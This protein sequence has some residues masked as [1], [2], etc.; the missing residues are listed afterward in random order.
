[1]HPWE[2][3][4]VGSLEEERALGYPSTHLDATVRG[5]NELN[6]V[7]RVVFNHNPK[8]AGTAIIAALHQ[9]KLG[10]SVPDGSLVIEK[11]TEQVRRNSKHFLK[12]EFC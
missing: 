12:R 6:G 1:M 5:K 7:H 4:I 11:E 9:V 3:Y 10:S 8:A 2:R